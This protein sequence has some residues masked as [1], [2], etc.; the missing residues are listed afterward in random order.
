MVLRSC[1]C[2]CLLIHTRG[3]A[4][5]LDARTKSP[6]QVQLGLLQVRATSKTPAAF[7]CHLV[8]SKE[9]GQGGNATI[10]FMKVRAHE[11][12]LHPAVIHSYIKPLGTPVL[13]IAHKLQSTRGFWV[14]GKQEKAERA[15]ASWTPGCKH[16]GNLRAAPQG[17]S[18]HKGCSF[19]HFEPKFIN[20]LEK[21]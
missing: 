1:Q 3:S 17:F 18:V 16:P 7:P 11:N 20:L 8:V 4:Q 21:S 5:L 10:L 14:S 13:C 19:L 9:R 2:S 6:V 12:Y 15:E